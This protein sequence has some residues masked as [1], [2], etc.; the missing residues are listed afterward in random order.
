LEAEGKKMIRHQILEQMRRNGDDL[1]SVKS[2]L[3]R[4]EYRVDG[5]NQGLGGVDGKLGGLERKIDELT[6]NLP[7]IVGEVM[8]DVLDERDRKR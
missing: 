2:R 8:R 4:I 1:A 5:I 6:R 3:E 7:K